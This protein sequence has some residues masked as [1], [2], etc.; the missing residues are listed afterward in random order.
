VNPLTTDDV[1]DLAEAWRLAS[2]GEG[3]TMRLVARLS[4][5]QVAEAIGVGGPTLARWEMGERR[6]TGAPALAWVRLLRQLGEDDRAARART[7]PAPTGGG[8]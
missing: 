1:R 5:R 4:V 7:E 3:R 2:S 8:S 6:P